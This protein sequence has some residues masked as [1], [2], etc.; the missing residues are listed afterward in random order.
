ML[1]M[2]ITVGKFS[3][4]EVLIYLQFYIR[5][6]R[7]GSDDRVSAALNSDFG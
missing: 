2:V 4:C 5:S 1:L 7:T 3:L 6:F